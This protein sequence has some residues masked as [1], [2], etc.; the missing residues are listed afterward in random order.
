MAEGHTERLELPDGQVA[1]LLTRLPWERALLVRKE[2]AREQ[3]DPAFLDAVCRAHLWTGTK[4]RDYLTDEWLDEAD[5]GK[6]S[7]P[8]VD[9]IQAQAFLL[10]IAWSRE[11]Y[12]K[13]K[14]GT[15]P[16]TS[17]T[18]SSDASPPSEA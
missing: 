16:E 11:A 13:G 2:V 10:F 15:E 14:A 8:V 12:P 7:P 18:S 5:Y 9:A 3:N 6:A 4:L 1:V 17:E